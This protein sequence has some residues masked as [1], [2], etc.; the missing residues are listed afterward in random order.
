MRKPRATWRMRSLPVV[1]KRKQAKPR[2][3]GVFF[4]FFS[5]SLRIEDSPQI[6]M[7]TDS[8]LYLEGEG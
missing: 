1:Q 3:G 5:F 2:S 6:N 7:S 4:V 8:S